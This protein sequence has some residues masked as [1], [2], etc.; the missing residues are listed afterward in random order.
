MILDEEIYKKVKKCFGVIYCVTDLTNGL[1]YIGQTRDIKQRIRQYRYESKT[2]IERNKNRRIQRVLNEKGIDNFK[3][4]I[5]ETCNSI[6]EMNHRERYWIGELNTTNPEKGYNNSNG[7]DAYVDKKG[8]YLD[9]EQRKD[10]SIPIIVYKDGKYDYFDGAKFFGLYID[11]PR[12]HIT[13][14]A[15][16]GIKV[17]DYYIFYHDKNLLRSILNEIMNKI[18]NGSFKKKID[19]DTKKEYINLGEELIHGNVEINRK[20]FVEIR[21]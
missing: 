12:T 9:Y 3:I 21:V 17:K 5:I 13:R 10:M 15:K 11:M 16:R 1:N 20:Y 7:G 4:T 6:D 2:F 8:T 14:G 18:E 19:I